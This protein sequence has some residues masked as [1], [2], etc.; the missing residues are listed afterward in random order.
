[1][2]PRSLTELWD[3][4]SSMSHSCRRPLV[5]HQLPP[6]CSMADGGRP[7]HPCQPRETPRLQYNTPTPITHVLR[8]GLS[9]MGQARPGGKGL[10]LIIP[11][12][13]SEVSLASGLFHRARHCESTI[14]RRS[15]FGFKTR[16][17]DMI[18]KTSPPSPP[19]PTSIVSFLRVPLR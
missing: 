6:S 15:R 16:H 8:L 17:G 13:P 12:P 5:T 2:N 3:G 11:P 7:F 9:R 1:M 14:P 4:G 10:V 19:P 18:G